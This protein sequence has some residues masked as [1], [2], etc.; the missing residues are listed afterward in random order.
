MDRRRVLIVNVVVQG[1][2]LREVV[3]VKSEIT[4]QGQ[5][6]F[7][8]GPEGYSTTVD[9]ARPLGQGKAMNPKQMLL[10]SICGCTGMDVVALMK[11]H[12]QPL[13]T[14]AISA[15]SELTMDILRSSKRFLCATRRQVLLSQQNWLKRPIFP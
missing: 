7:S 5:M 11:K 3:Q 10:V 12:K 6:E 4:W 2:V 14:F 1:I 15:E 9:A 13:E 8:G